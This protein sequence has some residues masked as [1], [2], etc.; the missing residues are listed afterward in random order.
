MLMILIAIP[1]RNN[2]KT[3]NK[4]SFWTCRPHVKLERENGNESKE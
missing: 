1:K 4:F 3:E 2:K